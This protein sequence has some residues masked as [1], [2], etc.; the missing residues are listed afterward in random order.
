M[1]YVY[2]VSAEDMKRIH[3]QPAVSEEF[4]EKCKRVAEKYKKKDKNISEC[5]YIGVDFSSADEDCLVV[6]RKDGDET[7]VVNQFRNDEALELYNKL[8]GK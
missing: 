7:Y 5:L 8:I 4:L 3:E 2:K 6:M 1:G